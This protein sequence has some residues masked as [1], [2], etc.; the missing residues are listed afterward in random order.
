[1]LLNCVDIVYTIVYKERN[2]ERK[3]LRTPREIIILFKDFPIATF[4]GA[5]ML[6]ILSSK[7]CD[8][9]PDSPS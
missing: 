9:F 8:L 2:K 3:S 7:F 1:M 4:F 5:F 6:E